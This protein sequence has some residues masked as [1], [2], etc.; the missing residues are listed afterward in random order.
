PI[1][2][3][4]QVLRLSEPSSEAVQ[5]SAIIERQVGQKVRLVDDLLDVNRINRGKIELRRG[6]IELAS[7]VHHAVEAARSMYKSMSHDLTVTLPP[8]PIYLNADPT[9]LTQVLGNLLNNACKFTDKGGRI[10]LA[11]EEDDGRAV[12]RVRDTGVGIA[13]DQLPRIFDMFTQI[14]TSLERSV[15]G[16]GIGLTLVKNL[17]EMHDGTVEVSSA[18]L[19][20]GSEFTVRLPVLAVTPESPPEPTPDAPPPPTGRRILIVD[21]NQ[22]SANTLAMLLKCTGNMT[23]TV[24]D[25]LEAVEAAAKFQPEVVLLDIGMPKLNG[26][27]VARKIREQ[28]WGQKMMLVALTGWGQEEDRQKSKEAG[29]NSHLVKP[30]EYSV[31]MKL[32]A[33]L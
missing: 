14:D 18:G 1:R 11:V 13:A 5:T 23:H 21:D 30:V 4:A 16:L 31:L 32:L 6:Q 22:D 10:S 7:H 28:P 24:Y 20:H 26:Y 19:G 17:V 9:R 25:G 12:I 15:S 29:F 33:E 2:N 3:A 8:K 27:E